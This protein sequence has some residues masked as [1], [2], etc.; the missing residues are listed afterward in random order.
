[1]TLEPESWSFRDSRGV[2]RAM[3]GNITGA[4]EDFQTLINGTDNHEWKVRRQRWVVV[5]QAGKDP[6]TDTEIKLL[7]YE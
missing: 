2:A 3:I 4:I 1:V 6:F 7:F 5:L